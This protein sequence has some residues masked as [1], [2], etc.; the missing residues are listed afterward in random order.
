M[1]QAIG[2]ALATEEYGVSFFSNGANPG[3]V[4][5]HPG[6]LKDPGKLRDSSAIPLPAAISCP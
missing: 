6:V 5:E 1:R 4:P 2:M 3:G